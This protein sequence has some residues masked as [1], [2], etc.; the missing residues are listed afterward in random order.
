MHGL[1]S[2]KAFDLE[3]H[4]RIWQCLTLLKTDERVRKFLPE[5]M[6]SWK[7]NLEY[8][9]TLL[10]EVSINSGIFQRLTI[11]STVRR[12]TNTTNYHLKKINISIPICKERGKD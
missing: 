4:S 11:A 8:G 7:V 2:E 9:T 5:S 12:G 6:K 1:T 3:P 10:G